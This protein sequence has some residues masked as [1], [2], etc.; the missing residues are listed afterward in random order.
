MSAAA[1]PQAPVEGRT[2]NVTNVSSSSTKTSLQDYFAFVGEI[3][4]LELEADGATQ[5]AKV[6]FKRTTAASSAVM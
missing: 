4:S 6:T 2:V 3:E 5:K 1:A